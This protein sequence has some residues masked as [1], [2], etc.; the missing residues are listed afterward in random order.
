MF[1]DRR[2]IILIFCI[3]AA[4]V[5]FSERGEILKAEAITYRHAVIDLR[6]MMPK[7]IVFLVWLAFVHAMWEI[8]IEGKS[9]WARELP[10]WRLNVFFRKL[11]GG[12][13]L[14]G[15][16]T[17]M[18]FLFLTFFHGIFLFLRWN[19]QIECLTIGFFLWYFIVEDFLWFMLNRHY[20]IKKFLS[21]EIPWH[22][23]WIG[24]LP[25]TY[26]IGGILGSILI[27]LG[28]ELLG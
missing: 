28:L 4:V 10:C 16:H 8:Q 9:G 7:L 19:V 14:T 26:W 24:P 21:K 23:R 2:I 17:W 15:Y 1:R 18:M 13:A 12:K 6:P 20:R 27:Y 22:R 25:L 11:L 5:I 3:V